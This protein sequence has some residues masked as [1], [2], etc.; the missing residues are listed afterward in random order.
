[1]AP[2]LQ[3]GSDNV[4]LTAVVVGG[5][6]GIRAEVRARALFA[7]VIPEGAGPVKRVGRSFFVPSTS[8]LARVDVGDDDAVRRILFGCRWDERCLLA[9]GWKSWTWVASVTVLGRGEQAGW[10]LGHP[11]ATLSAIKVVAGRHDGVRQSGRSGSISVRRP[12]RP[13]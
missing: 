12:R 8:L 10:L 13:E 6:C 4:R 9:E 7:Q 5:L 2:L 3:S 1:M 11:F